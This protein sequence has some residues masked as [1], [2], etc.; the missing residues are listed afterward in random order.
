MEPDLQLSADCPGRIGSASCVQTLNSVVTGSMRSPGR[1]HRFAAPSPRRPPAASRAPPSRG[2]DGFAAARQLVLADAEVGAQRLLAQPLLFLGERALVGRHHVLRARRDGIED[3]R[4]RCR[5]RA[6]RRASRGRQSMRTNT[7]QIITPVESPA[8]KAAA[9]RRYRVSGSVAPRS[10]SQSVPAHPAVALEA[11]A[12]VCGPPGTGNA[13]CRAKFGPWGE[14]VGPARRVGR[15]AGEAALLAVAGD[16]GADVALGG[17][18][19]AVRARG[20]N[21]GA[22]P[23]R[24]PTRAGGMS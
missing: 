13:P 8:R 24:A 20:G 15:V 22:A 17:Q 9:T 14:K 23:R 3:P 16:A 2:R 11:G 10:I 1:T 7:A 19:M 18:R 5:S 12:L 21:H 4:S 6:R